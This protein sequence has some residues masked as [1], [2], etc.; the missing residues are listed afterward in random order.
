SGPSADARATGSAR[1][2]GPGRGTGAGT[3]TGTGAGT[4][5]GHRARRAPGGSRLRR[6][7]LPVVAAV[8]LTAVGRAD[9][10]LPDGPPGG[11]GRRPVTASAAGSGGGATATTVAGQSPEQV[12]RSVVAGLNAARSRAFEKADETLLAD[13]NA[14]GS[15]AYSADVGV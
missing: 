6:W 15:P 5:A 7:L 12:W 13:V 14:P 10:L 11:P 8:G 4:G 2:T 9:V 1:R 3:G